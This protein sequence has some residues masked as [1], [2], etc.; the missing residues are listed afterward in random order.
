MKSP[1]G[2]DLG[3]LDNSRGQQN[4]GTNNGN[5]YVR[6]PILVCDRWNG[7]VLWIAT[8]RAN[9]LYSSNHLI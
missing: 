2:E 6:D 5:K 8:I 1:G 4:R 9:N 7:I 3:S